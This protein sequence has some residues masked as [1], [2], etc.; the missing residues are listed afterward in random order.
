[1]TKEEELCREVD[2]IMQCPCGAGRRHFAFVWHEGAVRQAGVCD[3]CD[4]YVLIS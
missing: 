3:G 4:E 1:M 2:S